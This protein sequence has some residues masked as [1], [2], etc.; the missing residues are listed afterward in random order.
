MVVCTQLRIFAEAARA[1]GPELTRAWRGLRLWLP[2]HL[3][4]LAAF[5]AA[6]DEKLDLALLVHDRL[7]GDERFEVLAEPDLSVVAF[8]VRGGEAANRAFL[9]RVNA[10]QRV[11][12]SSTVVDGRF[13]LRVAILAHRTHRDRIDELLAIL[14]RAAGADAAG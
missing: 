2:L 13:T 12:L 4:G 10:S 11:V 14:D 9:A 8:R 6:L 1:V 3:H 5:R 7:A